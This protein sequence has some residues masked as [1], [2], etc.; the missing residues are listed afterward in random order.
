MYVEILST[1]EVWRA[2][3]KLE[4]LSAAPRATLTP[5]SFS[6][7]FPRAQFLDIRTVTNGQIDTRI[8]TGQIKIVAV[9][10]PKL[11]IFGS[12]YR[13]NKNKANS[14]CVIFWYKAMKRR[15]G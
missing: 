6:P 15:N 2:F 1:Q 13:G 8:L 9:S 4:L 14:V 7:N 3:K 12:A 5:L 10:S 11:E